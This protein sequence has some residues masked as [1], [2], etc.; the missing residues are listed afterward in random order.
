MRDGA[1]AAEVKLH[2]SQWSEA[3]KGGTPLH[4]PTLSHPHSCGVNTPS[5]VESCHA[6][7]IDRGCSQANTVHLDHLELATQLAVSF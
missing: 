5:V 7:V 2:Y 6:F 4:N 1:K 3:S